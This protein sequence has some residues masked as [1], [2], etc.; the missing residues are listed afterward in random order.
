MVGLPTV[1]EVNTTPVRGLYEVV[2]EGGVLFVDEDFK[3]VITGEMFDANTKKSLTS[4]AIQ[5]VAAL[6]S[7]KLAAASKDAITNLPLKDTIVEKVGNGKTKLYIFTDPLC[8][9]CQKLEGD[10]AKLDDV[11]IIR[12]PISNLG[13]E[14]VK[15]NTGIWCSKDR[16]AAWKQYGED[17]SKK[18]GN[19][20]TPL[21]RNKAVATALNVTGT[22]T[23]CKRP[24]KSS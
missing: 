14:S 11:S 20:D 18:S 24:A 12:V 3:V 19:C 8:S 23:L 15:V 7:A 22:P 17:K 6:R 10:L 5:K 4:P 1:M 21:E 9:Y 16:L 2:T 13:P